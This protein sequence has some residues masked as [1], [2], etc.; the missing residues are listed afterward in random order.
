MLPL[1]EHGPDALKLTVF[2]EEEDALNTNPF[3]YCTFASGDQMIV[4]DFVA[5]PCARI[6]KVADTVLAALNVLVPGCDAVMVQF[7][8][9]LRTTLAEETP[10]ATD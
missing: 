5:D 6:T 3:P 4:C 2:P 10:L 7:P 9:P 8:V 1:V